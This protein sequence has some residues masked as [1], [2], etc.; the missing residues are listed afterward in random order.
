M[1]WREFAASLVSSLA[2]PASAALIVFLLRKQLRSLLESPVKRWKAGPVEVE[3]WAE[4]TAQI[5]GSVAALEAA[6][7]DSG[8][9]ELDQLARLAEKAPVAAILSG[10]QLVER[11]V[12]RIAAGAGIDAAE[13]APLSRVVVMEAEAGLLSP[14]TVSAIRGL[15]V[16]RNLAAHGTERQATPERAREYVA[17]VEGVLYALRRAS[18]RPA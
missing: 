11:E 15:S 8:D 13:A 9:D 2:W 16:L 6:G 3:Y 4:E 5:A 14:E 7:V 12:R 18:P 17:L 1:N 10:F